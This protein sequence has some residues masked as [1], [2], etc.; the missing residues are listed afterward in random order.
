MDA[1]KFEWAVDKLFI[2]NLDVTDSLLDVYSC[3]AHSNISGVLDGGNIQFSPVKGG[4]APACDAGA[5]LTLIYKKQEP[6]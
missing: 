3:E 5:E 2:K 4:G 1:V 6:I